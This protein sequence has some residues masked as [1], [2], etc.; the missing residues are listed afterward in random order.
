MK[1][2]F[3]SDTNVWWNFL[4]RVVFSVNEE[5]RVSTKLDLNLMK[6]ETKSWRNTTLSNNDSSRFSLWDLQIISDAIPL[7]IESESEIYP[8]TCGYVVTPTAQNYGF[9]VVINILKK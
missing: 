3:D 9:I 7:K 2:G 1:I 8:Q 6:F 5:K 4:S